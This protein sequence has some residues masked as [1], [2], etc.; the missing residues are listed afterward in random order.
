MENKYKAKKVNGKTKQV[1]RLVMEKHLGRELKSSEIV[2][3]IDGDKSN[4]KLSNLML[5]PNRAAHAKFHYENGD[6]KLVGGNNRKQ[7]IDGK[8]ICFR[9][10][11]IKPINEFDTRKSAHLGILG[12]CK[13][14]RNASRRQRR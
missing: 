1:H 9:C 7:L 14:C 13:K 12:V 8:L 5:F 2:H 6:Y 4:N 3:H 11:K 10:R